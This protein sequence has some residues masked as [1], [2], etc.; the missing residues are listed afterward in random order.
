MIS[1]MSCIMYDSGNGD[2]VKQKCQ[3]KT[4]PYDFSNVIIIRPLV[5]FRYFNH[6]SLG[7][8]DVA[9]FTFLISDI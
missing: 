4:S 2:F 9:F 8:C 6:L 1:Q 7:N 3:N 5:I